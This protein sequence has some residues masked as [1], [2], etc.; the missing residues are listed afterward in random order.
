MCKVLLEGKLF[1]VR[2]SAHILNLIVRD[3]IHKVRESVKYLQ[4]SS[5]VTQKFNHA[6][7][8]LKLKDKKKVKM[9]CTT[10]WSS[11]FLMIKSALEM[12]ELF[13]RLAQTDRNYNFHH[14]DEKLKVAQ[15]I[16]DCLEH[17]YAATNHFS[18]SSFPT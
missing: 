14:N 3:F 2:C 1:H 12:K 4:R 11:T 9:D 10:R 18:G 5:F 13:W 6:K 17:F 16:C 15:V 8:Q 7:T